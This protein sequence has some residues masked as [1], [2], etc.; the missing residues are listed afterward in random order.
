MVTGVVRK[1]G[2]RVLRAAVKQPADR[3][4]AGVVLQRIID[5]LGLEHEWFREGY[6]AVDALTDTSLDSLRMAILELDIGPKVDVE[7]Y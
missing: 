4:S 1:S 7:T 6:V 3:V 2:H 5:G